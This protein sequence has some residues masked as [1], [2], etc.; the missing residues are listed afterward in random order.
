MY[1]STAVY[2]FCVYYVTSSYGSSSI[3]SYSASMSCGDELVVTF[4]Y[5]SHFSIGML[6]EYPTSKV[7]EASINYEHT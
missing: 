6:H 2:V 1:E 3:T 4:P 7:C 5:A